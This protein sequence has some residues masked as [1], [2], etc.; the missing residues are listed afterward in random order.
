M[1]DHNCPYCDSQF[2]ELL[3]LVAHIKEDHKDDRTTRS[4]Q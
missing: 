3:D 4:I 2:S 1:Q